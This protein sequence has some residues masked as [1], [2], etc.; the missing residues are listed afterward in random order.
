MIKLVLAFYL[1]LFP[2]CELMVSFL[3]D[4]THCNDSPTWAAHCFATSDWDYGG[5]KPTM[6]LTHFGRL[7][8]FI[9]TLPLVQTVS[10][11]R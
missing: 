7:E 11:W 2:Q 10:C 6:P 4:F 1:Y 5:A 8:A 3:D 9:I